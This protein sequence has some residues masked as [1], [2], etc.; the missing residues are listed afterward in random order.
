MKRFYIAGFIL[1]LGLGLMNRPAIAQSLTLRDASGHTLRVTPPYRRIIS[2]YGAH[3]ENLFALGLNREI[4]GVSRHEA[5]PPAATEKPAFSYHDDAEKFLAARPDLVL[6]RPM[7]TRGYPNLMR[8]LRQAGITVVSL[9]PHTVRQMFRYWKTL[10]VL[11]GREGAAAAMIRRFKAQVA[12]IRKLVARIPIQ[13]RKR[14]YFESIHSRMKTFAPSSI[15]LYALKTAGGIN[16]A[17]DAKSTHG[18]NIADYGKERILSHA[19]EIDVF[20]AQ[21][22][23]MNHVTRRRIYEEAG[24]EAIK[25]VKNHQVFIIDEMIVSRPTPRLIFGITQIGRFLYPSIFNDVSSLKRNRTLSRAHYAEMFVKMAG[26][27]FETPGYRRIRARKKKGQHLYG[28]FRDVDYR[29]V[30]SAYIE[31]AVERGLFR[32]IQGRRFFPDKPIRRRDIAY[33]LFVGLDLPDSAP[34]KI[35]DVPEDDPDFPHIAAVAGLGIMRCSG[36]KFRPDQTVTG[37]QAY[38]ILKRAL[39]LVKKKRDKNS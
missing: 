9:Q 31:T 15:S 39:D 14:V 29:R 5:Y 34:P 24:F 16:V 19:G 3:T 36:G 22:G 1:L 32:D 33:S 2:L 21:R 4:I 37:T 25:A 6:V 10:G 18:T 20:L 30:L 38:H 27:P 7:I 26:F 11:T 28:D 13:K 17:A 8:K 23:A 12:A 35:A